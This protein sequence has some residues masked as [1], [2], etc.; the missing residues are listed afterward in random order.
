[1]RFLTLAA[2]FIIGCG[3]KADDDQGPD[4]DTGVL[5]TTAPWPD[6]VHRPWV[7]EDESTQESAL[8]LV[9]GYIERDIPVGAIIIDSPWATGYSTYEWDRELF[10]DPQGMIDQFHEWDVRVFMWTVPGIN[11]DETELY[12]Y[13]SERYS[14]EVGATLCI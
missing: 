8:A 4:S 2:V 13:A 9:E 5:D 10:P 7:W 12:E 6:W 14:T 3:P 11:I 1:M